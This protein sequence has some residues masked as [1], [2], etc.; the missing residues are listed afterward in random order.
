MPRSKIHGSRRDTR[1]RV[2]VD[3]AA[4]ERLAQFLRGQTI[5]PDQE[6]E[7]PD[8]PPAEIGNFFLALVA[9]CHQTSPRGLPALEGWWGGKLRKGWDYLWVR[10]E[11]AARENLGILRPSWWFRADGEWIRSI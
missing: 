1:S 6:E 2:R 3:E 9:I 10:F 7:R 4:C 5:P 11:H 8:L